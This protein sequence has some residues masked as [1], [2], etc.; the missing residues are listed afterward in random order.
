MFHLFVFYVL[1]VSLD[2][3]GKGT[4]IEGTHNNSR[5]NITETNIGPHIDANHEHRTR[6]TS[7]T[8]AVDE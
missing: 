5:N 7:R 4:N 2:H 1:C 8:C 6:S 3:N